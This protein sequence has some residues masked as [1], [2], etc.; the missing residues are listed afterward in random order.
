MNGKLDLGAKSIGFSLKMNDELAVVE[1]D[2]AKS[3]F[4]LHLK[5]MEQAGIIRDE[6]G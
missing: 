4:V 3:P 2:G 1:L 6:S 5:D